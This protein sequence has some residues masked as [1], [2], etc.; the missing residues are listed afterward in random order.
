MVARTHRGLGIGRALLDQSVSWARA[1][2]VRK[3]ELH[4]FP[5]N[6]P[7]IRLYDRYGFVREGL[8]V[9]HYVRGD[10][11]VDAVLMAYLVP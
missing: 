4:V 10:H 8:R 1:A 5:W 7:A 11:D 6:E 2:G 9:G 3:L